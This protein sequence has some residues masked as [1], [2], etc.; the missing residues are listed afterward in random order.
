MSQKV[1]LL[2]L[3]D[4]V[5]W[6]ENPRDPIDA[7]ATDQDIVNGAL[8]DKSEKWALSKL[9][10]DMGDYY[11]FSELPTVVY[12]GTKPVVYDGNRRVILGKIKLHLV[13]ADGFDAEIIPTFPADIPCN[14][15][16]EETALKNVLRKHG[17][18]GSWA[19]LERDI[20]LNKFM[21]QPKSTFLLVE[22]NTGLISTHPLMNQRFVKDEIL[23]DNNLKEM[24]FEFKGET[25][26]SVHNQKQGSAIL[27]DLAQKVVN[28]QITTRTSRYKVIDVLDKK[29]QTLI[30][31]NKEN[32]LSKVHVDFKSLEKGKGGKPKTLTKRKP[33]KETVLFG[34]RLFLEAGDVND[35]HRDILDLYQFYNDNATRLSLS[36]STLIRM[37]LRLLCETAA[38]SNGLK[39]DDYIKAH[40]ANA[41]KNLSTDAKTSLSNHN[42]NE[43][44][45]IQLLHTGAHNYSA[46]K[47]LEQTIAISIILGGMLM[48]SHGKTV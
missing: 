6:S 20:F 33:K 11:D 4:L 14:I 23:K 47:S 21:H 25:L 26:F 46:S 35:L 34:T 17:D 45:L 16:D 42:V 29:S 2:K 3:E 10:L 5:L 22:E 41:K 15:C 48:S 19:P 40:F 44:S 12:H 38:G 9:A 27:S 13:K 39:M 30:D 43:K 7:N 28:K 36:F 24:G 32:S 37:A 1:K 8:G 31:K 18:S